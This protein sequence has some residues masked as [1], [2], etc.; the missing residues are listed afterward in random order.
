MKTCILSISQ[1]RNL[2][3]KSIPIFLIVIFLLLGTNHLKS[4]TEIVSSYLIIP[5]AQRNEITMA[6]GMIINHSMIER[7][8]TVGFPA[9]RMD[10]RNM[11][12]NKSIDSIIDI[13]KSGRMNFSKALETE[14]IS[15]DESVGDV[16]LANPP[17]SRSENSHN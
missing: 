8:L 14:I 7:F 16:D 11:M 2:L 6:P 12:M 13:L 10:L 3:F 17:D 1:N 5:D 4:Q 15:N 9:E